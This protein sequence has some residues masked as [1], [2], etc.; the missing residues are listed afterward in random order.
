MKPKKITKH[1]KSASPQ[2][3]EDIRSLLAR[4]YSRHLSECIKRGLRAKKERGYV[5]HC[6]V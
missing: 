2:F 6:K 4:A 1:K 3:Q 5:K